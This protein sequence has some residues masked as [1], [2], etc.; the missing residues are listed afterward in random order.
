MYLK[1]VSKVEMCMSETARWKLPLLHRQRDFSL[2]LS[3]SHRGGLDSWAP[4]V[5]NKGGSSRVAVSSQGRC[6]KF[7]AF[8]ALQ[9]FQKGLQFFRALQ[10]LQEI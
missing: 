7:R 1:F 4:S 2:S 8:G 9:D 5:Q 6:S 10:K 3:P